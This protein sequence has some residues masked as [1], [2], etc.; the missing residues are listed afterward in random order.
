MVGPTEELY[1]S[2]RGGLS[3]M[4]SR[5]VPAHEVE[6][7]VQETYIRLRRAVVSQEIQHPQSYL[8]RTA[9][10][11]ALDSLKRASN[12]RSVEWQESAHYAASHNDL[13]FNAIESAD[14]FSRFCESVN[15]LPPRAQRVFVLKKVYGYTQREIATELGIS[16]ST[17]ESHVALAVRRC[18][19]YMNQDESA[20]LSRRE[21]A[22][23]GH[24]L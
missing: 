15:Q 21:Q 19:D 17:V 1:L 8:Y 12:S 24:P 16:E 6:D 2:L 23:G 9:R 3:K 11:L 10:N 20:A 4:L 18:A 22:S 13:V 14:T 7:I 5:M